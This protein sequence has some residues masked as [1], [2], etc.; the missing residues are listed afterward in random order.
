[1]LAF[2]TYIV[3]RL[4]IALV[5][6]TGGLAVA[7]FTFARDIQAKLVLSLFVMVLIAISIAFGMTI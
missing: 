6:M 4:G 2:H 1:M 7:I 5:L 3:F